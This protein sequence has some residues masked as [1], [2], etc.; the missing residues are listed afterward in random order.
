MNI[1]KT[2]IER[3]KLAK[4]NRIEQGNKGTDEEYSKVI[5]NEFERYFPASESLEESLKE[6]KLIREGKL[7]KNPWRDMFKE[8]KDEDGKYLKAIKSLSSEEMSEL[9]DL[10]EDKESEEYKYDT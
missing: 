1:F 5:I 4:K 10:I 2:T 3:L 6:M 7:P 8:L 9:S